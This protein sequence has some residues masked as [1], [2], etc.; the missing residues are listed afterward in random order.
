MASLTLSQPKFSTVPLSALVKT[1]ERASRYSSA[2]VTGTVNR[3]TSFF[4]L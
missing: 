4:S 2:K 1:I 3:A